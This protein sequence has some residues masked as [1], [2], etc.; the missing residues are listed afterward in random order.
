[1]QTY[2]DTF[3]RFRSLGTLNQI[4]TLLANYESVGMDSFEK[5]QLGKPHTKNSAESMISDPIL[6]AVSLACVESDEAKTLI[7]SLSEKMADDDLTNL[8]EQISQ[9]RQFMDDA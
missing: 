2:M 9:Q 5:A 4:E 3:A 7:P 8:C 6:T 1:M